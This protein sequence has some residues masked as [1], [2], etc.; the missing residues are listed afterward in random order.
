MENGWYKRNNGTNALIEVVGKH[1]SGDYL[2]R[3]AFDQGNP[4]RY[5]HHEFEQEFE[6]VTQ[7]Y[8]DSIERHLCPDHGNIPPVFAYSV[9]DKASK[10]DRWDIREIPG[11][12]HCSYCGSIH[13]DDLIELIRKHGFGIIQKT[14]KSYKW[15]IRIPGHEG[16]CVKYY[17]SHDANSDFVN[18]YNHLLDELRSKK[19]EQSSE[20]K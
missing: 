5:H 20:S 13:P 15:Y 1:E 10:P 2:C 14:D 19:V 7:E 11:I 3:W 6:S 9:E 18:K 8:I 17:R 4:F 12:R 16:F